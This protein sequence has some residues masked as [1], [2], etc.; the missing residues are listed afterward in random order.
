MNA[1]GASA[2]SATRGRSTSRHAT[3][4]RN[5]PASTISAVPSPAVATRM[6]AIA[7]PTIEP[8]DIA[9]ERSALAG[10]R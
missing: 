6:P 8:V 10:C 2:R 5:V 3:E 4:T 1:S 9:I 7:G